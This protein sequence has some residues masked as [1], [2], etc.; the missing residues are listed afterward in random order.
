MPLMLTSSAMR[1]HEPRPLRQSPAD[2]ILT[3]ARL[4]RENGIPVSPA[5]TADALLGISAMPVVLDLRE[6]FHA[7]L[8]ATLVKST[9]DLPLFSALFDAY[10]GVSSCEDADDTNGHHHHGHGTPILEGVD[11][12]PKA[13]LNVDGGKPVHQHGEQ[14]N[15]R[16]F[17]GE[18]AGRPDHDHHP[19]DR[20]R[21]TW[22]GGDVLYDH[23]GGPPSGDLDFDGQLGLRRVTLGGAPGGLR[24]SQSAVIP[25]DIVLAGGDES[26]LAADAD[27]DA[28]SQRLLDEQTSERRR[29]F[30]NGN[31][32]GSVGPGEEQLPTLLPALSWDRLTAEDVARLD[33]AIARIARR[34]GGAQGSRR[35]ARSGRLDARQTA[36]RAAA[37]GG[38]PFSPVYRS[39]KDDR[40]RLVVL[41][42][43]SLSVRGAA[44]FLLTMSRGLQRQSGRVRSFVYVRDVA[45]VTRALADPD[46]DHAIS[47]IFGGR[48]IDTAEASDGG[49]ALSA[50]AERY[51]AILS[52]RTTVLILGDGR[53]NGRDPRVESLAE[54]RL[55]CRR[56][57][58]LS[59][60]QRGTWRLAGC[61]LPRYAPW[62]D[63]VESV[64]RPADVERLLQRLPG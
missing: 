30:P 60:E 11:L 49:A 4:L 44:R 2:Q 46:L 19:G 53:N 48:L 25:R 6:S 1:S 9:V 41:C 26:G 20:L 39:R 63:L 31:A 29:Q 62:C 61:D 43:A 13:G 40:P 27:L 42:D 52:R 33:Q 58:W 56:I 28:A 24:Q 17:F 15:L 38:I 59:P 50:F 45:E 32:G 47:D 55:R 14:L 54:L 12:L 35:A 8:A 7:V 34:I 51:G 18:G 10:W 36:R 64:R 37:T 57:V 3:F 16:R 5:E 22:I 21:L 23:E